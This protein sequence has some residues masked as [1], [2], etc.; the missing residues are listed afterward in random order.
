MSANGSDRPPG[1]ETAGDQPEAGPLDSMK[2]EL[3]AFSGP[4]DLLLHLIRKNKI[5]I[6]D[7]PM[8]QVTRQYLDY[9]KV[10]REDMDM[11]VASEFMVMA[12]TLIHIKS[13][14]LLPPEPEEDGEG[15]EGVDPREELVRRLLEYQKYKKAAEEL[16]RQPVL[17][18]DVFLHPPE[19]EK[20]EPGAVEEEPEGLYREANLFMLM[21]AFARVLAGADKR[22]PVELER[23]QFHVQDAVELMEA[24]FRCGRDYRFE[25]L[26]I[27][28]DT[29]RKIVTIFLA[30]LEL[31]KR[32]KVRAAQP[33]VNGPLRLFA[34]DGWPGP[35]PVR[36]A[37]PVAQA[38]PWEEIA[39]EAAEEVPVEGLPE[40]E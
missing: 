16:E 23:E 19:G 29:R 5:D 28:G 11:E 21:D 32:E 12:A 18:R 40:E 39:E 25:E 22:R 31:I 8:A 9:L 6:L 26:F 35:E 3:S 20:G 7:I 24:R 34:C 38:L 17:G 2:V 37:E 27:A 36:I 14:M 13:R 30:L 15:E 33:E 4:L 1:E 10:M